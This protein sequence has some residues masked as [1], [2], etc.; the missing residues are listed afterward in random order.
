MCEACK[1]ID[2][3]EVVREATA[4]ISFATPPG[5]TF[6]SGKDIWLYDPRE[7]SI[8]CQ[9][10]RNI[11]DQASALGGFNGNQI[12]S[13]FPYAFPI[14]QNTIGGAGEGGRGLSHPNCRCWLV[15]Y[16]GDPKDSVPAQ[17]HLVPKKLEPEKKEKVLPRPK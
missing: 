12:R 10:C 5:T 3:V 17:Q 13:L 9:I 15:R 2:A 4:R 6:F 8:T 7:D 11:A 1:V 14:D 16:I